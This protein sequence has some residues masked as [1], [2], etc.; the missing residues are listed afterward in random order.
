[1]EHSIP[2][3]IENNMHDRTSQII[4][5]LLINGA[6]NKEFVRSF[7]LKIVKLLKKVSIFHF[8]YKYCFVLTYLSKI[9]VI[10]VQV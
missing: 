5:C 10:H 6:H 7:N 2:A 1:M 8:F 9:A 3:M 4:H